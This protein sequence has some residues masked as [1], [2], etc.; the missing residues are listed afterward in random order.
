VAAVIEV[1]E[2]A[3]A[4]EVVVAASVIEVALEEVVEAASAI[5]AVLEVAVVEPEVDS[6]QTKDSLSPHLINQ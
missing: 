5:E 2:A 6:I 1:E 4:A 3:S